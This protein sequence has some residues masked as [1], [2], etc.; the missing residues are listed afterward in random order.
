MHTRKETRNLRLRRITDQ[1]GPQ[2]IRFELIDN[3]TMMPLD[4]HESYWANLLEE[5]VREFLMHYRS[6]HNIEVERKA[7]VMEKI[8][9]DLKP[10][11]QSNLWPKTKKGIEQHLAKIYTDNKS[12]LKAD[13]WVKNP[14]DRTYDVEA[15]RS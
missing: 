3:D 10:H 4:D 5:I 8:R 9:F 12:A 6:W 7:G 1:F 13:H 14:E 11:V 15:I 2:E